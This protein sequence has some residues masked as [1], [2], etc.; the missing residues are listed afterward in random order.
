GLTATL[1]LRP[2]AELRVCELIGPVVFFLS[3]HEL[4]RTPYLAP[5]ELCRIAV[6]LAAD[7]QR[8]YE[9][10]RALFRSF[11]QAF[12]RTRPGASF[13]QFAREAAQTDQGREALAAWRRSKRLLAFPQAKARVLGELIARHRAARVLVFTA[14]NETAYAVAQE[15]LIMP[16]T[17]D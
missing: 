12:A 1:A 17:C 5:F 3:A 9:R 6:D 15:H 2:P 11:H 10:D 16:I 7:E 14:D 13:E 4:S 8:R